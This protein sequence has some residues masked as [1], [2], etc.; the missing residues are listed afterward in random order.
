MN[1]ALFSRSCRVRP[2]ALPTGT[3]TEFNL[4]SGEEDDDDDYYIVDNLPADKATKKT[5]DNRSPLFAGFGGWEPS[6]DAMFEMSAYTPSLELVADKIEVRTIKAVEY[7][8]R[9]KLVSRH[10]YEA[11]DD[12]IDF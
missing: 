4:R 3:K 9:D 12:G 5:E 7:Q 10:A 1:V 6:D 11:D 8:T 2:L